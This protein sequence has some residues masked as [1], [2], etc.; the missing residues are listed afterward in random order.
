VYRKTRSS[1]FHVTLMLVTDPD[2]VMHQTPGMDRAEQSNKE[3]A[4]LDQARPR[5]VHCFHQPPPR[6]FR[7]GL[8]E[9][10]T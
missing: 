9:W 3:K 7:A 5:G 2:F 4:V 10:Y 1:A 8:A 6:Q